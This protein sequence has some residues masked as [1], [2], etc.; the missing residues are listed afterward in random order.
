MLSNSSELF[1]ETNIGFYFK[2]PP[3]IIKL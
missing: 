3:R 2:S 1:I